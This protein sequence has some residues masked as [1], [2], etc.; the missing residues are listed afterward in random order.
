MPALLVARSAVPA[1][2]VGPIFGMHNRDYPSLWAARRLCDVTRDGP[3][4]YEDAVRAVL[5]D[6]WAMGRRLT[7]LDKLVAGKPSA[8]FPTNEEKRQSTEDGFRAFAIGHVAKAPDGRADDA[9]LWLKDLGD[10]VFYGG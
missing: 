7:A 8:M 4:S 6:A 9:T 10:K 5:A 2:S 1:S 3:R